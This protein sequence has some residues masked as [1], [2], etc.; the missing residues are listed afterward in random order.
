MKKVKLFFTVIAVL[1]SAAAFAQN[2]Q[3]SGVVSEENGDVVSGVAVQL[4]GSTTVYAMT[5][6][7]GNYTISVPANGTLVFSCLGYQTAEI[8]VNGRQVVN[9]T[10]APDTQLLEETIVVAYGQVKREA[11]TGSVSSV[12]G[13]A[14]ASAPVTSVDKALSGK[15]AGVQVSGSS[16]QPGASSN[17]RIRGYSSIQAS[18]EPLWV[19]DGIPVLN[20]NMSELTN[21]SNAIASLNPNDIESITVLKDAAAAAAYGSRAANGVIL[22]TTKS[23]K[24]GKAQFDVRAKYGVS[25]L[26]SDSGFRVM[27]AEELLDW[28]RTA[29]VNAGLNPDDPTSPYYYPMSLLN[30]EHT[31]WM[32]Y[33]SRPGKL[34]EYEI[35]ARGGDAKAKY[36]SSASFHKNEGT[37][38][39]I[40]YQKVQARVN[41][42]YK[43]SK[44]LEAGA[45]VNVGYSEQNDV[46]M[47][48]LYYANP[49]WAGITIFPW[50]AKEDENGLPNVNI[51]SNSYQNPRATAMFDQQWEKSYIMNGTIS[52]K[53]EPVQDLV[54]ETKNSA[55]THFTNAKRYWDPKARGKASDPTDQS[56]KNQYVQLTTSNTATYSKIFGG[57]HSVRAVLGQEAMHYAYDYMYTYAPGCDPAMPYPNTAPAESVEAEVGFTNKALLSFFG[58]ADYNYDQKYFLQ[59]TIRTD[60]SSLFGAENKWGTFWSA[61]ASWNIAKEDFMSNVNFIDLL[62][63]RLSYGLNGNNGISA[64]QAYGLYGTTSY[65]GYVG[66]LPSQ[67]AN[68]YLSWEKNATW[69]AG[70]DFGFFNRIHGQLDVYNR[71]TLDMLLNKQVPQTTGFSTLFMN[72]GSMKNEGIELQMDAD[73]FS[74]PDFYW[75]VGFNIAL[76]KTTILDL[77]GEEYLGSNIRQVVGKSM[78][79]YYLYDYYGVN[80]MNGEA[81]WVADV[82]EETGEKTLT[83]NSAK[84]R[85]YYAGSPE[86]KFM[87]G[88]NTTLQWK[89]IQLSAFFEYMGGNYV[90]N[91]NE[92]SYL[93]DDGQAM[94]MN[95]KASALNYWKKPGD[96]ACNPKPIAGNTTNSAEGISDRWL[97]RGDFLRVKDVTLSYNLPQPVL[98]TLRIKGARVYV[99]G[100][101]LYCF[102][103]VDFWDP[104]ISLNGAGAGNYPLTKS[105]VGGIEVSF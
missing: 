47:Q 36:F 32:R 78:Y 95:Q 72:T 46:P 10:L 6:D 14:L 21:T 64:Y 22:V 24:E 33:L 13:D 20:G 103:D 9:A 93:N 27:T 58:I 98:N 26:Q 90:W 105:F 30:G 41:A 1:L 102:N 43:L 65:N 34:Q 79:T 85:K 83:N 52:L 74:T 104:Q 11:I 69:N 77:G 37:F 25:W 91:V 94:D 28:S 89:G 31:S 17:I 48:S 73:I 97:E 12:K 45:R 67:P 55:E 62:K 29:T 68:D 61:S 56:I 16:G 75:N 96:T 3:V 50:I 15:L 8:Q 63:L 18:N 70:L 57:Y 40:D 101:N 92:Y 54:L 87:G 5:N 80:P 42:D 86:P 38:Y 4:K 81:L 44:K 35:S 59:G 49:V 76:N 99:S 82:N 71:K 84:A 23:G 53:Y 7:L 60:G 51:A 2:V 100:L 88:F 66:M 39:G 19:V